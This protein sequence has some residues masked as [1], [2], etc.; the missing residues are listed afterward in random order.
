MKGI[1]SMNQSTKRQNRLKVGQGL[2][3]YLILTALVTMTSLGALK[4]LGSKVKTRVQQMA[5][6]FDHAVQQGLKG[7]SV[8]NNSDSSSSSEKR[9]RKRNSAIL[10]DFLKS[11]PS[12]PAPLI[13]PITDDELL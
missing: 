4:Y 10:F 9:S 11:Q 12:L 6:T 3:E 5:N 13:E 2:L 1:F 8:H 7:G